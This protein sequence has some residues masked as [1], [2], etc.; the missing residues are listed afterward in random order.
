MVEK[1]CKHGHIA[2][3]HKDGRCSECIRIKNKRYM[4]LNPDKWK[5]NFRKWREKNIDRDR[6][7]SREWQINNRDKVIAAIAKREASI[8]MRT[9]KWANLDLIN[10]IYS[11]ARQLSELTGISFHVDHII[12]LHGKTVSGLHV[13][14]NLRPLPALE[15]KRKSNIYHED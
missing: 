9:P 10:A 4:M 5:D 14:Y 7:K 11:E 12:P 6:A 3:R 2:S 1:L 13:H 15:N 8:E